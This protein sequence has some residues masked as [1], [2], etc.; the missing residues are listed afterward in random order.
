MNDI[1]GLRCY[2][3]GHEFSGRLRRVDTS[4][5][6]CGSNSFSRRQDAK[7]PPHAL[8]V[9]ADGATDLASA[10][11]EVIWNTSRNDEGTISTT[12]ANHVAAAV[13][14]SGFV[15]PIGEKERKRVGIWVDQVIELRSEV[16]R[17]KS[18]L[19]ERETAENERDDRLISLIRNAFGVVGDVEA[20]SVEEFIAK[21]TDLDVDD[22]TP[23]SRSRS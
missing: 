14:S 6:R 5:T 19:N 23:S 15:A 12:G 3:C 22:D 7:E 13:L 11:A 2:S 4:C 16:E 1:E 20:Y 9:P 8:D 21:S 10:L 17:L 18:E